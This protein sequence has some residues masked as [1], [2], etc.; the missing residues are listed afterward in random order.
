[1]KKNITILFTLFIAFITVNVQAQ[2]APP[3][4]KNYLGVYMGLSHPLG[5]FK[6]SDYYDNHAGFAKNGITYGINWAHYFSKHI[7]GVIDLSFQDQGR[8]TT[9][10]LQALSA[11]YNADYNA[12]S[13]TVSVT[14]RFQNYNILLGPQ[15]SYFFGDFSLDVG[16]SA[17]LLKSLNT[18]EYELSVYKVAVGS[19]SGTSQI[20]Y[21]R[22][23]NASAFAY[24]GTIGLH[25]NVS[26]GFGFALTGKYVGSEG[27][28]ITNE[29]NPY[30]VGRLVT[31]QPIDVLQ[32]TFGIFFH[33]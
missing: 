13:T 18:P 2:D 32:G 26:S 23:S 7:A 6:N 20:F 28:A 12:Q 19:T 24:S 25:Y 31:K 1:M 3:A 30:T 11:G 33:F 27:I 8:P 22:S 21:Q 15:Y 9:D 16:V 29:S 17:G 5:A 14:S 4:G 10:E